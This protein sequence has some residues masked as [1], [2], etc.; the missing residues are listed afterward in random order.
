MLIW[1]LLLAAFIVPLGPT[2]ADWEKSSPLRARLFFDIVGVATTL[3]ATWLAVRF[4]D[5]RTILSIGL[6]PTNFWRGAVAGAIVGTLWLALSVVSAWAA[7]WVAAQ[8]L[9]QL[10]GLVL[11][12]AAASVM[13]NV[14]AQQLLLCGYIFQ[15]IRRET[16]IGLAVGLSAL[17]FVG[18]HAGAF[19]DGW[20]SVVNVFLAGVLFCLARVVTGSL[21]FPVFIHFAWNFL[22]GPVLGLTVSGSSRLASGWQVLTVTGPDLWTGGQFGLEGGLLVTLTTGFGILA[23]ALIWT[24]RTNTHRPIS[25]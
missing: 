6:G 8:A 21:W 5:R 20:L 12:G 24:R 9:T 11:L 7:G 13:L 25:V 18:Y 22:L 4:V 23:M 14:L 16:N 1:A 10:S 3:A 19:T 17:L 15:V 2:L